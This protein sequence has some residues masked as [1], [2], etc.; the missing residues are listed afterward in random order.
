MGSLSLPGLKEVVGGIK[1]SARIARSPGAR[2]F[3]DSFFVV[4]LR[5]MLLEGAEFGPKRPLHIHVNVVPR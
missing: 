3:E 2:V 1:K 5:Y 4:P